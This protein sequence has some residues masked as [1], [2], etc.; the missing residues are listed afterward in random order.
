MPMDRQAIMVLSYE[1][2]LT[3]IREKLS[4][5]KL[6]P[7]TENVQLDRARGR[8][9]AEDVYADR[10]YPPFHRAT[11]DGYA[12]RSTDLSGGVA[13]LE[14]LGEV[15]AGEGFKGTVAPGQCVSIM[16]GAPLPAGA[17]AV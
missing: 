6:R 3:V 17:D 8:V 7:S 12:V 13:R 2:A 16:T 5:A 15:R 4:A 9:L 14:C 11:R 10:D 1:Q